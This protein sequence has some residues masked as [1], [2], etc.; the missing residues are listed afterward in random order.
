MKYIKKIKCHRLFFRSMY[1]RH[2]REQHCCIHIMNSDPSPWPP[3]TSTPTYH[4]T[5]H[6]H[7]LHKLPWN[8]TTPLCYCLIR[9]TQ[10]LSRYYRWRSIQ[11]LECLSV[12]NVW[13]DLW[14]LSLCRNPPIAQGSCLGNRPIYRFFAPT[15]P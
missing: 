14:I 3:T 15:F 2:S 1:S 6:P 10:S 8:N 4:P 13:C 7:T 11:C 12:V 5:H 9:Q